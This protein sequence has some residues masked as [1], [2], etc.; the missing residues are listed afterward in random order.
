MESTFI[1]LRLIRFNSFRLSK[2]STRVKRMIRV[3]ELDSKISEEGVSESDPREVQ[4]LLI[5]IPG[6]ERDIRPE[7]RCEGGRH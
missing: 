7:R 3:E 5:R 1:L 4:R 2:M 6:R